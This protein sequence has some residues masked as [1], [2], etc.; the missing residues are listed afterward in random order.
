M[1]S[2][3]AGS[4]VLGVASDDTERELYRI[5]GIAGIASGVVAILGNALHPR[6]GAGDL[7]DLEAQLQMIADFSLWKI[8]HLLIVLALVL[9][10]PAFVAL[11]R[12]LWDGPSGVWAR[13]ALPTAFAT[14]AVALV[15]FSIDGFVLGEVAEDWA[16][17]GASDAALLE[18]AS[19]LR[20]LDLGLFSVAIIGLFGVTQV[21]Y[22]LALQ[23]SAAY[24]GWVGTVALMGGVA[25]L[26]SGV[27][28]W[29]AGGLETGNFLVLFTISSV[30][31][32]VWLLYA[33]VLL[34]RR[35][36]AT[37]AA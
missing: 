37:P 12:S 17:S 4:T 25:G 6:S 23:R 21:L 30:L 20:Y 24:P 27:W 34:V 18:R 19:T 1:R 28:M 26:A 33:S 2:P 36:A 29:M 5:G 9:G 8:D 10:L 13:F 15:A 14:G 35:A 32:A 22:G 31:L 7:G 3:E 11:A 16:S